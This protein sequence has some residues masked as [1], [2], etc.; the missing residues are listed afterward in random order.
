MLLQMRSTG[1]HDLLLI[2]ALD[3]EVARGRTIERLHRA[4]FHLLLFLLRLRSR[5]L[6]RF[7]LRLLL[8]LG[9]R[10]LLGLCFSL[11]LGLC[12]SLFLRLFLKC[13]DPEQM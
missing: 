13:S 4:L 5:F 2:P 1:I 8:R 6:L 10:F 12:L 11:L 7:R 9:L 3:L